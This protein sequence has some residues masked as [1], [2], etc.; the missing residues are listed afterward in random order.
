MAN[1]KKYILILSLFF[2]ISFCLFFAGSVAAGSSQPPEKKLLENPLGGG[3]NIEN[4]MSSAIKVVLGL[5]GSVTLL[6]FIIGGVM[7]L[8]SGG[9]QQ[10]VS[11]GTNTMLYAAVGIFVI[12]TAYFV[13]RVIIEGVTKG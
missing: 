3:T 7:W 1:K 2:S 12:F 5:I 11:M 4:T 9:N 13:L 6:V 10:R 8:T